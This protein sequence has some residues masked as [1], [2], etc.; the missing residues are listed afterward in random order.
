MDSFH[1]TLGKHC[2]WKGGFK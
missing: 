1:L 2:S